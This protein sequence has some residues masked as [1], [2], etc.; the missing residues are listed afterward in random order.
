MSINPIIPIW[1]MSIICIALLFLKRKGVWPYIRQI[2]MVLLLFVVNLGITVPNGKIDIT[3]KKTNAYVLL[4]V[5]KT[6]SMIAD[7][8]DSGKTR[9]DGV[10]EQCYQIIDTLK[11]ARIG[12][13]TFDNNPNLLTTFTDNTDYVKNTISVISTMDS[14][15]A[16]G[17]TLNVCRELMKSTL[18]RAHDKHDGK[19][20]VFFIS[21]GEI[22]N[23][24]KLKSFAECGEYVDMGAVLGYGTESGGKMYVM[25]YEDKLEPLQDTSVYPYKDAISKIDE[26][27]LNSVAT[28]LGVQYLHVTSDT[29]TGKMLNDIKKACSQEETEEK[30]EG[31]KGIYYYFTLPLILLFTYEIIEIKRKAVTAE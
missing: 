10:K 29:D 11:G 28:D 12:V 14:Y 2:I 7:D 9:M 19:V 4:V 8:Y 17:S 3:T 22:T 26:A 24:D 30:K 5:D 27:N 25:N 15:Y 13:I 18:K 1:L 21:D 20:V 16:R 6:I 23:G 31:R